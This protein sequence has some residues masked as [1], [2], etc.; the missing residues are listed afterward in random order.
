[1]DQEKGRS[2]AKPPVEALRL[3]CQGHTPMVA[4]VHHRVRRDRGVASDPHTAG[5]W[6]DLSLVEFGI[7][8][9]KTAVG[10]RNRNAFGA[11]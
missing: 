5:P 3:D 9:Q 2:N 10:Q 1:M 4:C 11:V 7:S 8:E 6:I